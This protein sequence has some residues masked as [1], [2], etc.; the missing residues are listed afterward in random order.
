[1]P[2]R[3][4]RDWTVLDSIETDEGDRCV[5]LFARPDGSYGFE[6]FRRDPEDGGLWTPVEHFAALRYET[7]AAARAAAKEAVPWLDDALSRTA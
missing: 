3:A 6:A 5:D 2:A 1:M 4:T 7:E